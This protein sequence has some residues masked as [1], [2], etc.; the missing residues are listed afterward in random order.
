[1]D[2]FDRQYE[3]FES[4]MRIARLQQLSSAEA[5]GEMQHELLK[6]TRKEVREGLQ[7]LDED[8][9]ERLAGL[10]HRVVASIRDMLPGIIREEMH[11]VLAGQ[12]EDK[13]A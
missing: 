6:R 11:K 12:N 3:R 5:A 1:M 9:Q 7:A 4:V 13:D 10:E 8:M 2:E